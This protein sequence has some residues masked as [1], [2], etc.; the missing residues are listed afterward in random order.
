MKTLGVGG[1]KAKT[2]LILVFL[3][4]I[5]HLDL[6][7]NFCIPDQRACLRLSFSAFVYD[8]ESLNTSST[9]MPDFAFFSII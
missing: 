1:F 6:I 4:F 7:L 8:Y 2:A 5:Q 9:P 3:M